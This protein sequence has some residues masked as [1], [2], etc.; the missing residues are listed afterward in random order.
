MDG[1]AEYQNLLSN[2]M[3]DYNAKVSNAKETYATKLA[4]VDAVRDQI[5]KATDTIGGIMLT[6]PLTEGAK[7]LLTS[8]GREELSKGLSK[9]ADKVSEKLRPYTQQPSEVQRSTGEPAEPT[10]EEQYQSTLGEVRTG[11]SDYGG[12]PLQELAPTERTAIPRPPT[13]EEALAEIRSRPPRINTPDDVPSGGGEVGA[14][15]TGNNV[16]RDVA[17]TGQDAVVDDAANVTKDVATTA[18][19]LGA[20]AA[21]DALDAA[22]A[23]LDLDPFTAIFGLLLGGIGAIVG[24]VEGANSIKNP[25]LP[26]LPPLANTSVQMGVGGQ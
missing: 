8:A 20:D 13:Q 10:V 7:K 19:N 12:T 18:E 6:E 26:K 17:Q 4:S 24:G 11:A 14:G 16:S 22:G 2:A 23:A 25:T 1:Y 5:E 3:N 15:S 21:G 9:I